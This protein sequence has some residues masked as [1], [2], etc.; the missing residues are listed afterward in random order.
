MDVNQINNP[1]LAAAPG[2]SG[3]L[4]N[5]KAAVAGDG[6]V[7]YK[8]TFVDSTGAESNASQPVLFSPGTALSLNLSNVPTGPTRSTPP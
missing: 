8:I 1:D 6:T 2:A 4:V 5:G 3:M 7:T